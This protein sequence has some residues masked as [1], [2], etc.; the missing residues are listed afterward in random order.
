[1]NKITT[2]SSLFPPGIAWLFQKQPLLFGEK[3]REYEQV[4][5]SLIRSI[6][7][8]NLLEWLLLKQAADL[9]WDTIRLSKAK[10]AIINMTF[11]EALRLV[12]ETIVDGEGDDRGRAVQEH[13]DSWYMNM[14]K[15]EAT[16]TLLEK[17]LILESDIIAQAMALRQP[18]LDRI[19][20]SLEKTRAGLNATLREIAHYRIAGTWKGDKDL[21]QTVDAE[22]SLIIPAPGVPVTNFR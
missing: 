22:L 2:T 21:Q 8:Q 17:R 16:R 4:C 13:V 18:E 3:T 1:M 20:R 5:K 11:L 9:Y 14:E 7:P 10:V 12:L 6:Q 15:Q 19:D